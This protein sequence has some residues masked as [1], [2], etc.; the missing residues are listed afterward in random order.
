MPFIRLI[1]IALLSSTALAETRPNVV[2]FLTDDQG[3]L[4]INAFGAKDLYTP[5]MDQIAERGIRFTQSY[6]HTVCCPARALLLTGR[7][8][9]R[10]GVNHWTQGNLKDKTGR[11]MD[12]GEITI[13]EALRKAGYRTG[14]FGKWHLGAAATHGPTKQGFDE[15]FGHRGGFI[16][17]YNH[18]FLHGSGFH[19]LYRGVAEQFMRDKYFP[20]LMTDE[21]LGF[22]ERNRERPFFLYAAFNIP[23]YPEQHD[24]KFDERYKDL[25]M[26]RRSYARILSTTDDRIGRVLGKLDELG[27]RKNTMILFMSDNG[28]SKES[29]AIRPDNHKSGLPKGHNY[30]ANGGGGFSG[31]WRGNKGSFYEGGI[32]TPAMISFPGRIPKGQAR[33]QAITAADFMP[34]IL[35]YCGIELPGVKLDGQSL[36]TIIDKPDSPTHH[37]V[38]HWQWSKKWAVREGNW[39][40]ISGRR[41]ELLSL[42]GDRPESENFAGKHPEIVERLTALHNEWAQDVFPKH[43]VQTQ[44]RAPAKPARLRFS[45]TTE[46]LKRFTNHG[47]GFGDGDEKAWSFNGKG[48]YLDLKKSELANPTGLAISVSARIKA[49]GSDGVIIA[50]GGQ[51]Q[52]FSLYLKEGRPCF[53]IRAGGRGVPVTA[54]KRL[55]TG[56]ADLKATLSKT[57]E[58]TIFVN[59]EKWA[60][61]KVSGLV[62]AMPGDGLQ[63]GADTIS[64]VGGYRPDNY[65]KGLIREVTVEFGE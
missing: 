14:L 28:A 61:G 37:K 5:N 46:T 54:K 50:Q 2:L 49:V 55:P 30:G 41:P 27:L 19:D 44:K 13:A 39:K 53:A 51:T 1:L 57:K 33:D 6:A 15:F 45:A 38:M 23:H 26:P 18:F 60:A 16:D 3:T 9:Q 36:R 40:L 22:I 10:S 17:N 63:I 24:A 8:P 56:W 48:Q 35:D 11:N 7:H 34:T 25:P 20:D 4:D 47:V 31:K 52:G 42:E 32:R 58:I 59:G 12:L 65:F 64:P 21:A 62:S 43:P 29:Y